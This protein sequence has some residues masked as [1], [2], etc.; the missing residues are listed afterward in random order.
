MVDKVDFIMVYNMH[1]SKRATDNSGR[2]PQETSGRSQVNGTRITL[3][4]VNRTEEGPADFLLHSAGYRNGNREVCE[5]NPLES[6]SM[7]CANTPPTL[8]SLPVL[9]EEM[10]NGI[11]SAL[12]LH[13]THRLHRLGEEGR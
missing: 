3:S 11:L 10:A 13:F 6:E 5:V 1:D 8:T 7:E 9:E 2:R 12:P 4:G